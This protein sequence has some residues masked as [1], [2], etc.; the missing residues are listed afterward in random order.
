MRHKIKFRIH[1]SLTVI[2][3]ISQ[4]VDSEFLLYTDDSCLVFRHKDIKM[5]EERL[6]GDFSILIDWFLDNKQSVYLAEDKTKS[7]LFSP[8]HR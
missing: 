5:I 8:K 2:L 6:N 7:V 4:A 1:C 3:T